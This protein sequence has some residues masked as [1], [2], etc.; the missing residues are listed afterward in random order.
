MSELSDLL[1]GSLPDTL[2]VVDRQGRVLEACAGTDTALFDEDPS[3]RRLGELWTSTAAEAV[4]LEVRKVLKSR[5]PQNTLLALPSAWGNRELRCEVRLRVHGRERVLVALRDADTFVEEDAAIVREDAPDRDPE[6]GLRTRRWL[7][8][9]AADAFNSARLREESVAI[10]VIEFPELDSVHSAFGRGAGG[11]LLKLAAERVASR[12]RRR[13]QREQRDEIALLG[14]D[15]LAMVVP[16][17][18]SS[19]QV[20]PLAERIRDVLEDPFCHDGREFVL[21]SGIGVSLFPRDG[22][23]LGVL[24]QNAHAALNDRTGAWRTRPAFFSD[25]VPVRSLARLDVQEELRVAIEHDRLRLR[26]SPVVDP[27]D[28]ALLAVEVHPVLESPLRGEIGTSRLQAF[29][30]STGLS[31]MLLHQC[32]DKALATVP[33]LLVDGGPTG[34]ASIRVRVRLGQLVAELPREIVARCRNHGVAPEQICLSVPEQA[35]TRSDTA[36]TLVECC[37]KGIQIMLHDFGAERIRLTDLGAQTLRGVQL[38]PALLHQLRSVGGRRLCRAIAEFVHTLEMR[39]GAI[40]V[41]NSDE[42]ALL[43]QFGCD[44]IAGPLFG[45]DLTEAALEEK[46]ALQREDRRTTAG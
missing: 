7:A 12:I 33:P 13:R 8:E 38:A 16:S 14:R 25:T 24:L 6:T 27:S 20:T 5:R 32:I 23:D 30:E 2:L 43:L 44:E 37:R 41:D 15:A 18:S 10:V 21:R 22:E 31:G 36:Q 28:A 35:I 4:L 26:Y 42:V 9:R 46:L 1:A 34:S 40:S 19:E 17:V 45:V 3:G 39:L 29:A 11:E